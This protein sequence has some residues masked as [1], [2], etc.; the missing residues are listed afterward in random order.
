MKFYKLSPI[1]AIAF[2]ASC[3]KNTDTASVVSE[4]YLHKYGYAVSKQEWN[5]HYYP[6]QV[7]SQMSNGVV[8]TT[9]YEAGYKHGPT[10]YTYPD[11][12]T[13]EKT[14]VY[15]RDVLIKEIHFNSDGYPVWQKVSLSPT[16]FEYT[17]WYQEGNPRCVEE[18]AGEE[19][20]E[21][22]YFTLA[23]DVEARVEKGFGQ[24]IERNPKG[25]LVAR[26]DIVQ[27][28]PQFGEFF[29]AN[30]TLKETAQYKLGVLNGDR[31]LFLASGEPVAVEEYV[32]GLLHGKVT[33]YRNGVKHYDVSYL[34]GA[35]NGFENHYIDGEHV[36]HQICWENNVKHGPE[37]FY[38]VS[39]PVVHYFYQGDELSRSRYDEMIRL[40]EMISQ[41][42]N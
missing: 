10:T 13:I 37:T 30:G 22:R 20:L 29:H 11:S 25:E 26:K 15:D 5:E 27:G 23:G 18:F 1:L 6:G 4:Q 14:E 28:F 41:I 33:Y 17:A 42:Q 36:T 3:Q 34:F 16:R 24:L 39:G 9:S 40:D 21:G 32:D 7:I 19:L 31:K 35:K 38:M 12:N 8:I 2:L